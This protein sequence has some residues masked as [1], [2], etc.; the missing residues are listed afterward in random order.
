MRLDALHSEVAEHKYINKQLQHFESSA[1]A[2]SGI[3][4]YSIQNLVHSMHT[5]NDL[6]GAMLGTNMN[7]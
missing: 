4:R 2:S 5:V 1:Q 6:N 7:A 3:L